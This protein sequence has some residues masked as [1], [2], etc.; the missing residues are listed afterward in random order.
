MIL[1]LLGIPYYLIVTTRHSVRAGT[2][3]RTEARDTRDQGNVPSSLVTFRCLELMQIT[4]YKGVICGNCFS[5]LLHFWL[6]FVLD[7]LVAR[8]GIH[9]NILRSYTPLSLSRLY[10]RFLSES[11]ASLHYNQKSRPPGTACYN[12]PHPGRASVSLRFRIEYE[13]PQRTYRRVLPCVIRDHAKPV[14]P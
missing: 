2:R 13:S 8:V 14:E 3:D 4:P 10:L 5:F 12:I 1:S 9:I 11:P 7:L 6:S